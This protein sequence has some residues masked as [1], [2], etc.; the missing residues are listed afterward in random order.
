VFWKRLDKAK[1]SE[2]KRKAF[3]MGDRL[4]PLEAFVIHHV[5]GDAVPEWVMDYV[6]MCFYQVL[7]GHGKTS[8]AEVFGL[9][10]Q[11]QWKQRDE[12]D[13]YRELT[14][15]MY[16]LM[17]LGI[18]RTAAAEAVTRTRAETIDATTLEQMYYRDGWAKLWR[19]HYADAG[20]QALI[21][22]QRQRLLRK[23]GL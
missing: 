9:T 4:A 16:K 8:I 2:S 7:K 19:R 10:N 23:Y 1:L 11:R 18:D 3:D 14:G 21:K 12:A 13:R 5:S 20:A 15:E 17:K 6:A 22:A